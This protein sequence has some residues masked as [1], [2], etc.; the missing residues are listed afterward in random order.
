MKERLMAKNR[1]KTEIPTRTA[2][3]KQRR[4]EA[5]KRAKQLRVLEVFRD[6]HGFYCWH[7]VAA[8]GEIVYVGESFPRKSQ[9]KEAAAREHEG[10]SGRYEY[11]LKWTDERSG[12]IKRETL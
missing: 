2:Y 11:V 10:R 7:C 6:I 1:D 9:A 4:A 12:E 8:N 5:T 3:R